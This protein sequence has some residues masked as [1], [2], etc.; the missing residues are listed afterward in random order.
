MFP[1]DPPESIRKPTFFWI[2]TPFEVG[3]QQNTIQYGSSDLI[4]VIIGKLKEKKKLYGS[5]ALLSIFWF[6]FYWKS[7][8]SDG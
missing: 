8:M 3:F 6:T 5:L 4:G 1:F 7:I 2:W